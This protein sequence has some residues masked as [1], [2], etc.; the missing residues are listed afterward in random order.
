MKNSKIKSIC[1]IPARSGSKRIKNK[2][3][4]KFIGKPLISRVI[5]ILKKSNIFEDI[6]VSTDSIKIKKIAEKSGAI[7]PYLR[8][9]KLSNDHTIIKDVID[10]FIYKILKNKKKVTN[11]FVV[12]PTSIFLNKKI[13]LNCLRLLNK[14]EYVTLLK[15]FPHP[16]QRALKYKK[17][18]LYPINLKEKIMRTQDL[19]EYFYNSGQLDCF[20]IN[21]WTKKKM[22]HKMKAK[23]IILDELDSIDIDNYNDLKLAIKI[24][25][26]N[27][28]K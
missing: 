7:V 3:I 8:S 26:F 17:N 4:K 22:F 19:Q 1:L 23:F 2:N 21:A 12:Y 5:N 16:I 15:K 9:K 20:K 24:F 28:L 25:K 18:K 13:L 11:L 14:T 6:F 10:D 27:K